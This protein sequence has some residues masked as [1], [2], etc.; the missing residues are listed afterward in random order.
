MKLAGSVMIAA[1]CLLYCVL[2]L[3]QQKLRARELESIAALLEQMGAELA[4]R[5]TPLPELI[6]LLGGRVPGPAK[7]FLARLGTAMSNLG[8]E[9]FYMIWSRCVKLSFKQLMADE[10]QMLTELGNT[11]GRYELQRQLQALDVCAGLIRVRAA[12]YR[13]E[14]PGKRKLHM[15]LACASG[16]L[17]VIVLI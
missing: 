5:L 1:A 13:Q 9:S 4:A 8:D 11:L 16:A 6:E 3:G 12:Q 7:D 10:L 17:L 14:L 15:G 2:Y